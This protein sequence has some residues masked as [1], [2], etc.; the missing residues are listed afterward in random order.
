[1]CGWEQF[2][3]EVKKNNNNKEIKM[4]EFEKGGEEKKLEEKEGR[5]GMYLCRWA[6]WKER[7]N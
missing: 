1:M 3:I 4:R 5:N 6:I 7:G 2:K